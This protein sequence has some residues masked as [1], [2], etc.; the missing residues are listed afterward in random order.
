VGGI[1]GGES[2][3]VGGG[4]DGGH[5]RKTPAFGGDV[6]GDYEALCIQSTALYSRRRGDHHLGIPA[7]DSAAHLLDLRSV[8]PHYRIANK[9]RARGDSST[10]NVST[11]VSTFPAYWLA[12]GS[13]RALGGKLVYQLHSS[14]S[15]G[16]ST[17]ACVLTF[18]L[19]HGVELGRYDE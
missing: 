17:N 4:W 15:P 18:F 19:W 13:W 2:G 12:E 14:H 10:A 1:D 16:V 11:L 8:D 5:G 6:R 9:P 3:C 7:L